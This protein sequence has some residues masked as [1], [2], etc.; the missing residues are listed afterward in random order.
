MIRWSPEESEWIGGQYKNYNV[1][2]LDYDEHT[3]HHRIDGYITNLDEIWNLE[4][5]EEY[6]YTVRE[7]L[8]NEKSWAKTLYNIGDTYC[9]QCDI[10]LFTPDVSYFE[11]SD[12]YKRCGIYH[13][14]ISGN[15]FEGI[16]NVLNGNWTPNS[17]SRLNDWDY[18]R[19]V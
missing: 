12:E 7:H 9:N 16:Y 11:L 2:R 19:C 13:R 8:E 14:T 5:P 3:H 15:G 17:I 10:P 18:P 1:N 4:S 6:Q